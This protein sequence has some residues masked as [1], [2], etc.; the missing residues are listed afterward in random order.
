MHPANDCGD[1][2]LEPWVGA[3]T[4][5]DW[6][7][8]L[9]SIFD[10]KKPLAE[11]TNRRI[12]VGMKRFVLDNPRPFI[13]PLCHT[14]GSNGPIDSAG[15]IA[16]ITTAKGGEFAVVAPSL[17][18]FYGGKP[19]R[20]ERVADAREPLATLS[21]SNRF[22]VTGAVLAPQVVRTNATAG[23]RA[24]GAF[25][26]TDPLRTLT[27]SGEFAL[28]AGVLAPA[29]MANNGQNVGAGIDSPVPA[30]TTGNRNYVTAG[31]LVQTGYGERDG[32][33]PRA[34]DPEQ[35]IGTMVAGGAK[36]AVVAAWMAQ[37]NLG[38]TGHHMNE[39]LSTVT[40]RGTQQQVAGAFLIHQRG[41]S[42]AMPA[43]G[44]VP[45]LTAGG[46][47]VAATAAFMVKYYGQG[48]VSQ[49]ADD[50]LHSITSR[51]RFGVVTVDL[52]GTPYA[53]V[54]IGMRMLEPHEAAAA[55]ELTLP[56]EI[57]HNGV[58]RRLTKTEAMHLIGNSVPKRMA[59][60]LA[61]ANRAGALYPVNLGKLAAD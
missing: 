56:A 22:G 50:A 19:G 48:G 34:L 1:L 27:T 7:L 30:L 38:A 40:T 52:Q 51:M 61:Q 12:A 23:S 6:S 16:T 32:Q 8:P 24:L 41:T 53:V 42:T 14:K 44:P 3:H 26:V 17:S 37:H 4:I 33:A 55:H 39:P 20:D 31:Y 9:P 29:I 54:D 35:P 28:A 45:T 10:R 15:P 49:A 18:A 11:A 43:D 5:I 2:G 13:V 58:R 21:T 57:T 25:D 46:G 60:L 36:H 47:H 59:R